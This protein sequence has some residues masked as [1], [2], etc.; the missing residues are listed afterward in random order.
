MGT[1]KVPKRLLVWFAESPEGTGLGSRNL[2]IKSWMD[3]MAAIYSS[4]YNKPT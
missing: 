2:P 4:R 3:T 1:V